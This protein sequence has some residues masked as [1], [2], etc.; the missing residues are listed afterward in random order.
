[1]DRTI[2]IAVAQLDVAPAPVAERLARAEQLVTQAAQAGA[3]LIALPELFN[4]GYAYRDENFALAEPPDGTTCAWMKQVSARLGVHLAGSFLLR[5]GK[6][7]YNALMLYAPD[8]RS[9][10]Y[11][12]NY[13]WG[14]ERAYFRG[15]RQ[16]TVADTDLGNIGMLLCWDVGHA[17]LWRKYGG[18]IDLMLACSCPPNLVDPT[19][20]FPDGRQWTNQQFGLF[21]ANSFRGIAQQ[22]F[23]DTPAQQAA[24]LGIP[25]ANTTA[26]GYFRSPVPNPLGSFMGLFLMAGLFRYLP[27]LKQVELSASMMGAA[28]IIDANGRQLASLKDEQGD[29][30]TLANITIPADRPQP[31]TPQ[32]RLPVPRPAYFMCDIMLPMLSLGTYARRNAK[33]NR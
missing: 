4:T 6:E 3:Q 16:I 14:W 26:C 12:K 32:P 33:I 9:W 21:L 27:L 13:P 11:D 5:D 10:R 8:G 7:I 1:M 30:F 22:V 19:Y 31:R 15:R 17:D 18:K 25:Y 23:V 29:A 24:W 2:T 20:L 28:Q